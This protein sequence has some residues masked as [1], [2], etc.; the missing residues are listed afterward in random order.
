MG[1]GCGV[2]VFSTSAFGPLLFDVLGKALAGI[3][4]L[5]GSQNPNP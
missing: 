4:S 3:A 1:S 2:Q 5:I